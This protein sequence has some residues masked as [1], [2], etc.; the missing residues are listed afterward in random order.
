[1]G[2][3]LNYTLMYLE[4]NLISIVLVALIHYKTGG[5]TKMVAQRNFAMAIDAEMIFFLSDTMC[6]TMY[7]GLFTYIPALVFFFKTVY[8]LSTSLM[9]FY[10]FV[11]FEHLQ[12]TPFVKNRKRVLE[13]SVLVWVMGILLVINIFTG[14]CFYIDEDG[15]YNRG[16]LFILLGQGI[17][18]QNG[19]KQ[20]IHVLNR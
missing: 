2:S 1:M 4:I 15:V 8:F 5:L 20:G 18:H 19:S 13:S 7:Y 17:F 9:C 14:C 11:Y 3:D 6:V 16:K 10:W 12:G